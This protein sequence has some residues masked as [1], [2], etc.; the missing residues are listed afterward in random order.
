MGTL[1]DLSKRDAT[2]AGEEPVDSNPKK[3]AICVDCLHLVIVKE[4]PC[5]LD[6][7]REKIKYCGARPLPMERH[8]VEGFVTSKPYVKC[9]KANADGSCDL[10]EQSPLTVKEPSRLLKSLREEIAALLE[11]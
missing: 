5:F 1:R 9:E 3:A 2:A 8:P 10:F 11:K 6:L 4:R 7:I